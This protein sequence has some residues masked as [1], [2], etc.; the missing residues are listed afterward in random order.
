MAKLSL[1]VSINV[2]Y[3]FICKGFCKVEDKKIR[4]KNVQLFHHFKPKSKNPIAA[5]ENPVSLD[6]VTVKKNKI[7]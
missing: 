6:Q 2:K 3:T 4:V 1:F 7:K 5:R